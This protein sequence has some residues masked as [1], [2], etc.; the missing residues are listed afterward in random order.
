MNRNIRNR[1][2]LAFRLYKRF[3][4]ST[5]NKKQ[6]CFFSNT[7]FAFTFYVIGN[8]NYHFGIPSLFANKDL[9]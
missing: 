9:S 2:T 8:V 7:C 1:K 3:L 5:R 6:A 4:A